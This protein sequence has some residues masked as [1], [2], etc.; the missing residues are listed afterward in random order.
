M[1]FMQKHSSAPHASGQSIFDLS[2]E[3]VDRLKRDYHEKRRV[4]TNELVA[5]HDARKKGHKP[6]PFSDYQK[7]VRERQRGLLN[8]SAPE[9]LKTAIPALDRENEL[10]IERD[11]IDGILA[12]LDRS[13]IPARA[14]AAV[15]W[16]ETHEK[17]WR[18]LAREIALTA[19]KLAAL[20]ARAEAMSREIPDW[21]P[22]LPLANFIGFGHSLLANPN[23]IDSD[24]SLGLRAV[25]LNEGIV[26][27]SEI[28]KV[29]S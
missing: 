24:S 15:A 9:A 8:G 2:V 18:E 22:G 29:I 26:T 28:K 11:A 5:I 16:V 23:L 21:A 3:E 27:T 25:A 17:Q 10:L 19:F 7:S 13:E 4:A 14:A 1:S 12:L 20:E 6:A